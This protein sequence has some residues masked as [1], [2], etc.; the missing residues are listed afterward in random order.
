LEG[1]VLCDPKKSCVASPILEIEL[2]EQASW[3]K[4]VALLVS[5]TITI[6]ITSSLVLHTTPTP[7][8]T[9]FNLFEFIL[10]LYLLIKLASDNFSYTTHIEISI[11]INSSNISIE[12][13]WVLK[14][15]LNHLDVVIPI[16]G[17]RL[18]V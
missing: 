17:I 4:K 8:P 9:L 7:F 18:R 13:F 14:M 5:I 12:L 11:H 15:I 16:L 1:K 10:F 6:T 3:L 2:R